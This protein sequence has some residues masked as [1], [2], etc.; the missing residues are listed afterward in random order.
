MLEMNEKNRSLRQDSILLPANP[1]APAGP[2]YF[3][4]FSIIR[5]TKCQLRQKMAFPRDFFSQK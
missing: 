2:Y 1:V 5:M 3:T 4:Q